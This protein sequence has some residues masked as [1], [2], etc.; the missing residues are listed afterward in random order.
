MQPV[1]LVTVGNPQGRRHL[2]LRLA[3]HGKGG[4]RPGP[5]TPQVQAVKR[6]MRITCSGDRAMTAQTLLPDQAL[7]QG[8]SKQD[9]H[10]GCCAAADG[11]AGR[12]QN[13]AGATPAT[14]M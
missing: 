1:S 7:R 4:A 3:H 6:I 9:I 10:Q 2:P 14:H 11:Q 5:A 12:W 8:T 13:A